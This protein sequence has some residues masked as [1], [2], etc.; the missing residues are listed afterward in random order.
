MCAVHVCRYL[1]EHR[2]LCPL[3]VSSALFRDHDIPVQ[4]AHLIDEAPWTR[5]NPITGMKE[6][7][8]G[9]WKQ[10]TSEVVTV[11]GNCWIALLSLICSEE[12]RSGAYELNSFRINSFVRLR[13]YM[14]ETLLHQIP[15]LDILK[16]FI[17]E[18]NVSQSVG[19]GASLIKGNAA[20]VTSFSPFAI[21]E[22][23]ERLFEKLMT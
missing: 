11:E 13:G 3:S 7:L 10:F 15:H 8:D 21:V 1:I 14:T 23:G 4:L 19:S 18:I 17:E 20:S 22:V 2:A 12:V 9:D 5:I 6:K 16:R